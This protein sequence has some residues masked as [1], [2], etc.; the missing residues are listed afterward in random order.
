MKK[1]ITLFLAMCLICGISY[2][3]SHDVYMNSLSTSETEDG[4]SW[5]TAFKTFGKL[6]EVLIPSMVPGDHYEIWISQGIYLLYDNVEFSDP[7]VGSD[8]VEVVLRGGCDGTETE[9]GQW[10]PRGHVVVIKAMVTGD[11]VRL[12]NEGDLEVGWVSFTD[13]M[14]PAITGEADCTIKNCIFDSCYCG[15]WLGSGSIYDTVFAKCG[16]GSTTGADSH[17]QGAFVCTG[18]VS[19]Y[20][21]TFLLNQS[22]G[23]TAGII[24]H[25]T[26]PHTFS[27]PSGP[28]VQNSIFWA[29][30]LDEYPSVSSF[31]LEELSYLQD[32]WKNDLL[33]SDMEFYSEGV[34][35]SS[36]I[37]KDFLFSMGNPSWY[38]TP[39]PQYAL[40]RYTPDNV[41]N[42]CRDAGDAYDSRPYDVYGRSRLFGSKIDMGA[43][44]YV[45]TYIDFSGNPKQGTSS[46]K[47]TVVLSSETIDTVNSRIKL[48]QG[49]WK[50]DMELFVAPS[51]GSTLPGVIVNSIPGTLDINI[52]YWV[53]FVTDGFELYVNG[54]AGST[55]ATRVYF[56]SVGSGS[57]VAG[58]GVAY[59]A[60]EISAS[61]RFD[62][63]N[64]R[65]TLTHGYWDN[66]GEISFEIVTG[67]LPGNVVASK[68]YFLDAKTPVMYYWSIHDLFSGETYQIAPE[69]SAPDPIPV[70]TFMEFVG[71]VVDGSTNVDS[72]ADT[73]KL[74]SGGTSTIPSWENGLKVQVRCSGDYPGNLYPGTDY[75]TGSKT[76]VSGGITVQLL[77]SEGGSAVDIS[78]PGVGNIAIYLAEGETIPGKTTTPVTE[79]WSPYDQEKP[80]ST[81]YNGIVLY[82]SDWIDNELVVISSDESD[83][84]KDT[85]DHIKIAGIFADSYTLHT[86]IGGPGVDVTYGGSGTC[87]AV[88]RNTPVSLYTNFVDES[89]VENGQIVGW[90]W[91]FDADGTV[92]STEQNPS[93]LYSNEGIYSVRLTL[94][95]RPDS[96]V[97]FEDSVL[98]DNYITVARSGVLLDAD[99]TSDVRCG[100]SP[101]SVSFI[102]NTSS[103]E[104]TLSYNWDFGDG[105]TSTE[106]NPIHVYDNP[107][108]YTVKYT[109]SYMGEKSV[110]EKK[111]YVFVPN[112]LNARFSVDYRMVTAPDYEVNLYDE[113]Y[114]F[115]YFTDMTPAVINSWSWEIYD[116]DNVLRKSAT[117]TNVQFNEYYG[118]GKY[119]VKLTI[120]TDDGTA[121]TDIT[122]AFEILSPV[123]LGFSVSN[124]FIRPGESVF[125]QNDSLL[126]TVP[127]KFTPDTVE[128]EVDGPGGSP[129]ITWSG[130][131][132]MENKL[133]EAMVLP[134]VG[135]YSVKMTV[136]GL[137]SGSVPA[138]YDIEE[139]NSILV[140]EGF[141]SSLNA[142][143]RLGLVPLR[144]NFKD[145]SYY[146]SIN[147][148]DTW[149]WEYGDGGANLWRD[150]AK[151]DASSE[152]S[153]T[154]IP[155][156][157]MHGPQNNWG[158]NLQRYSFMGNRVGTYSFEGTYSDNGIKSPASFGEDNE[159]VLP[160][161]SSLTYDA[162]NH[163]FSPSYSY[164][165][166]GAYTVSLT[167]DGNKITKQDYVEAVAPVE[168][169]FSTRGKIGDYPL[170]VEFIPSV[171]RYNFTYPISYEWEFEGGTPST[172]TQKYP[173]VQYPIPSDMVFKNAYVSHYDVSLTV[174]LGNW[175]TK[176]VKRGYVEAFPP[177]F[178]KLSWRILSVEGTSPDEVYNVELSPQLFL[179]RP[180]DRI[181]LFTYGS[182]EYFNSRTQTVS[183]TSADGKCT[184]EYPSGW[185]MPSLL[186][187]VQSQ[188][189]RPFSII[190]TTHFNPPVWND[191]TSQV[192]CGSDI[193]IKSSYYPRQGYAPLKVSAVYNAFA[194]NDEITRMMSIFLGQDLSTHI[195]SWN[196]GDPNRKGFLR[197]SCVLENPGEYQ[198][199]FLAQSSKGQQVVSLDSL[200][201]L[202]S[203]VPVADFSI[204]SAA[205]EGA[206]PVKGIVP[207]QV[208]FFDNSTVG[209]SSITKWVWNFGDSGMSMDQNPVHTYFRQGVYSVSLTITTKS[210]KTDTMVRDGIVRAMVLPTADFTY[211]FIPNAF[212]GTPTTFLV[213]RH[214]TSGNEDGKTWKTGF[215]T[216]QEAV[217]AAHD[218]GGG[219]VW[220]STGWYGYESNILNSTYYFDSVGGDYSGNT[221]NE[222]NEIDSTGCSDHLKCSVVVLPGGVNIY[223]GFDLKDRSLYDRDPKKNV[224]VVSGTLTNPSISNTTKTDCVIQVE[225]DSIVDG[226]TILGGSARGR[227]FDVDGSGF[228]CYEYFGFGGGINAENSD[229]EISNCRFAF[230]ASL[231]GGGAVA[232]QKCTTQIKNC[233]FVG[234]MSCSGSCVMAFDPTATSSV[235]DSYLNIQDS[236]F[237]RNYSGASF[238]ATSVS[239][240]GEKHQSFYSGYTSLQEVVMEP[241]EGH[242]V[243]VPKS[244]N[245]SDETAVNWGNV[246]FVN[247]SGNGFREGAHG[248]IYML[249][250][251]KVTPSCVFKRIVEGSD[252]VA[253][254][255]EPIAYCIENDR[256][257]RAL[258]ANPIE[259]CDGIIMF[260]LDNASMEVISD[261]R[262]YYPNLVQSVYVTIGEYVSIDGVPSSLDGDPDFTAKCSISNLSVA[263]FEYVSGRLVYLDYVSNQIIP[264]EGST[265]G[266]GLEYFDLYGDFS[267]IENGTIP[268]DSVEIRFTGSSSTLPSAG[269]E[270]TWD[271][272]SKNI[273]RVAIHSSILTQ[274]YSTLSSTNNILTKIFYVGYDI[275]FGIEYSNG[276]WVSFYDSD[277]SEGEYTHT[278]PFGAVWFEG[279]QG[280]IA[281]CVFEDNFSVGG[282]V[283]YSPD[284]LIVE[285]SS[286]E[287]NRGGL[288]GA[289]A[290]VLEKSMIGRSSVVIDSCKFIG[291]EAFGNYGGAVS[292]I[293]NAS[294]YDEDT[295]LPF[296]KVSDPFD[297][298]NT[299]SPVSAR[300]VSIR[301]CF[302]SGNKSEQYGSAIAHGGTSRCVVLHSTFFDN[303]SDNK[304]SVFSNLF[305]GNNQI[306]LQTGPQ[307]SILNSIL[308][309]HN[310]ED[311]LCIAYEGSSLVLKD[312]IV[313][314][315]VSTQ[316][317]V[318][319]LVDNISIEN[320][321]TVEGYPPY[322][323]K[324]LD[325]SGNYVDIKKQGHIISEDLLAYSDT[326]STDSDY[327]SLIRPDWKDS[328][329]VR[330]YRIDSNGETLPDD[331]Q[332]YGAIKNKAE[333]G[334]QL[335][336][337]GGGFN[338]D[339]VDPHEQFYL[340]NKTPIFYQFKNPSTGDLIDLQSY[341]DLLD[342]TDNAGYVF[343]IIGEES[344]W[345]HTGYYSQ[346]PEANRVSNGGFED[347]SPIPTSWV[348]EAG[349]GAEVTAALVTT[350][351]NSGTNAWQIDTGS[352]D[353]DPDGYVYQDVPTDRITPGATYS[354]Y[355]YTRINTGTPSGFKLEVWNDGAAIQTMDL[356]YTSSYVRTTDTFVAPE[357][358]VNFQLRIY[359]GTVKSVSVYV[360]DVGISWY[361][362]SSVDNLDTE[363]DTISFANP[364]SV[365]EDH[366]LK[367]NDLIVF[368]TSDALL[369]ITA[370]VPY[371]LY[372]RSGT[373]PNFTFKMKDYESDTNVDLGDTF[374]SKFTSKIFV[375]REEFLS[376]EVNT[377]EDTF[378]SFEDFSHFPLET[379]PSD[380]AFF[381][382][383][384]GTSPQGLTENSFYDLGE[385]SGTDAAYNLSTASIGEP[386][387][388]IT[389]YGYG[390]VDLSEFTEEVDLDSKI[391]PENDMIQFANSDYVRFTGSSDLYCFA[392][393][394]RNNPEWTL[395]IGLSEDVMYRSNYEYVIRGKK[396]RY[397]ERY[398]Y[399]ID[400]DIVG[401][402]SGYMYVGK[403]V[404]S[405]ERFPSYKE[406]DLLSA[407]HDVV[408]IYDAFTGNPLQEFE[409]NSGD[410]VVFKFSPISDSVTG[411]DSGS[412]YWLYGKIP[413]KQ[414][415]VASIIEYE[416]DYIDFRREDSDSLFDINSNVGYFDSDEVD[417]NVGGDSSVDYI[418]LPEDISECYE[419][420]EVGSIVVL[421]EYLKYQ[422]H[423]NGIKLG[424][425]GSGSPGQGEDP[426]GG[427]PT[428]GY[429][430]YVIHSFAPEGYT[431]TAPNP[432]YAAVYVRLASID[433][434]GTPI[435]IWGSTSTPSTVRAF[436]KTTQAEF[437]YAIYDEA[438]PGY[439]GKIHF[440]SSLYGNDLNFVFVLK[441]GDVPSFF[442]NGINRVFSATASTYF[443]T[444]SHLYYVLNTDTDT[445]TEP[446]Y[447]EF[448]PNEGL[449]YTYNFYC[450]ED[451]NKILLGTNVDANKDV[452]LLSNPPSDLDSIRVF[453]KDGEGRY[454]AGIDSATRYNLWYDANYLSSGSKYAYKLISGDF[455]DNILRAENIVDIKTSGTGILVVSRVLEQDIPL[456]PDVLTD[457]DEYHSLLK[458]SV[459]LRDDQNRVM[460]HSLD[461]YHEWSSG[462]QVMFLTENSTSLTKIIVPEY[463]VEGYGAD[464]ITE[465]DIY[466][467]GDEIGSSGR[468]YL[469][470]TQHT[471]PIKVEFTTSGSSCE[472]SSIDIP[473]GIRFPGS[474]FAFCPQETISNIASKVNL[475]NS[476]ILFTK[477]LWNIREKA[478]LEEKKVILAFKGTDLP[479]GL[480]QDVPYLAGFQSIEGNDV[481]YRVVLYSFPKWQ[482]SALENGIEFSSAS[483]ITLSD[484]G[485]GSISVWVSR[486]VVGLG[487]E[488]DTD[489][490][491][492][493]SN[494]V[495]LS[496]GG[497]YY[498][499]PYGSTS[500]ISFP[501]GNSLDISD[502]SLRNQ[503]R[504]GLVGDIS[505]SIRLGSDGWYGVEPD[506]KIKICDDRWKVGNEVSFYTGEGSDTVVELPIGKTFRISEFSDAGQVP[507]RYMK[508]VNASDN[509]KFVPQDTYS[510][511]LTMY[512][513]SRVNE[514]AEIDSMSIDLQKGSIRLLN[515]EWEIG[516]VVSV[517][518]PYWS[519]YPYPL[520]EGR[521]YLIDSLLIGNGYNEAGLYDL[522]SKSSTSFTD[523]AR[524]VIQMNG[525]MYLGQFASTNIFRW[526]G[527]TGSNLSESFRDDKSDITSINVDEDTIDLIRQDWNNEE[528]I[529]FNST[530]VYSKDVV[531]TSPADPA[532]IPEQTPSSLPLNFE[533]V[534][535]ERIRGVTANRRCYDTLYVPHFGVNAGEVLAVWGD[536]LIRVYLGR[537]T[538]NPDEPTIPG[539]IGDMLFEVKETNTIKDV[540]FAPHRGRI[541]VVTD[542]KKSPLRAYGVGGNPRGKFTF[543]NPL[544]G[545]FVDNVIGIESDIQNIY[546]TIVL[547]DN[548]LNGES[549]IYYV[550]NGQASGRSPINLDYNFIPPSEVDGAIP[551]A[552][553]SYSPSYPSMPNLL[554][555]LYSN[556]KVVCYDVGNR[557]SGD[558]SPLS[559]GIFSYEGTDSPS[560]QYLSLS[561]YGEGTTGTAKV[562]FFV[563]SPEGV[564]FTG[565]V[566][567]TISSGA[568]VAESAHTAT[569]P[570]GS[571]WSQFRY[572]DE[573]GFVIDYMSRRG[574]FSKKEGGTFSWPSGEIEFEQRFGADGH[575]TAGDA[576]F[577]CP[578]ILI[579]ISG[580][581]SSSFEY[582]NYG[583]FKVYDVS[584][585]TY[586]SEPIIPE[587]DSSV[588]LAKAGGVIYGK[589]GN[590]TPPLG[591]EV[592]KKYTLSDKKTSDSPRDPRI[593]S[594]SP[595]VDMGENISLRRDLYGQ[596]RPFGEGFDSGVHEYHSDSPKEP[597]SLKGSMYSIEVLEDNSLSL[598]EISLKSGSLKSR[599][600]TIGKEGHV[601]VG[602]TGQMFL[603]SGTWS[604]G[605]AS[606]TGPYNLYR[607]NP[608]D[609]TTFFL[610]SLP[611][612]VIYCAQFAPN[613]ALCLIAKKTSSEDPNMYVVST[614]DASTAKIT[615]SIDLGSMSVAD[616]R[617]G[618]FLIQTPTEGMGD[619]EY[620]NF[621]V[622]TTKK[623]WVGSLVKIS[624]DE[625]KL[626]FTEFDELGTDIYSI[627]LDDD[628][629]MFGCGLLGDRNIYELVRS[630]EY[631][632]ARSATVFADNFSFDDTKCIQ[633]I[634]IREAGATHTGVYQFPI[635]FNDR[636]VSPGCSIHNWLWDFGDNSM[637][638]LQNPVH[639][640][641]WIGSYPVKMGV[642]NDVG[643]DIITKTL[644]IGSLTGPNIFIWDNP[645]PSPWDPYT[646]K[647]VTSVKMGRANTSLPYVE[648]YGGSVSLVPEGDGRFFDVGSGIYLVEQSAKVVSQSS[649]SWSY[650]YV[651][652]LDLPDV[653]ENHYTENEWV[654]SPEEDM[655]VGSYFTGS[656]E[657]DPISFRRIHSNVFP[658]GDTSMVITV[659]IMST[660]SSSVLTS[661]R[662]VEELPTPDTGSWSFNSVVGVDGTLTT[663]PDPD[664]TGALEFVWG[665]IPTTYPIQ[666]VYSVNIPSLDHQDAVTFRGTMYYY[667]AGEEKSP[668]GPVATTTQDNCDPNIPY[669]P[670]RYSF[671]VSV[672]PINPLGLDPVG[673]F[674][675]KATT[676]HPDLVPAVSPDAELTTYDGIGEMIDITVVES[677][678]CF[679][680]HNITPGD[681]LHEPTLQLNSYALTESTNLFVNFSDAPPTAVA[682]D[683]S[684]ELDE[685]G[686]VPITP[687]MVDDGSS[688]PGDCGGVTLSTDVTSVDCSSGTSVEGIL[689]ARDVSLQ[690]STD[691]FTI[692]V[693]DPILPELTLLANYTATLEFST[694]DVNPEDLVDTA[695]DN[696]I[697]LSYQIKKDGGVYGDSISYDCTEL[698]NNT[699]WVKIEDPFGN[700]DEASMTVVVEEGAYDCMQAICNSDPINLTADPTTVIL[701]MVDGGSLGYESYDI[702][703]SS[704]DCGDVGTDVEITLTVYAGP[705]QTGE[706]KSCTTS[707]RITDTGDICALTGD[708]VAVCISISPFTIGATVELTAAELDGGSYV[709]G[710]SDLPDLYIDTVGN[711]TKT[712]TCSELGP[713]TVTLIAKYGAN[714]STCDV[715]VTVVPGILQVMAESIEVEL[716]QITK[717][718]TVH[719]EDFSPYIGGTVY[720]PL[721]DEPTY[722]L[723]ETSS[724]YPHIPYPPELSEITFTCYDVGLNWISVGSGFIDFMYPI[725]AIVS[726]NVLDTVADCKNYILRVKITDDVPTK[727]VVNELPVEDHF[728]VINLDTGEEEW[729][730]TTGGVATVQLS[731]AVKGQNTA[732]KYAPS[733]PY[734]GYP[735]EYWITPVPKNLTWTLTTFGPLKFWLADTTGVYTYV[736]QSTPTV[737]QLN[738]SAVT[739]GWQV[740]PNIAGVNERLAQ[741]H[742]DGGSPGDEEDGL[743]PNRSPGAH[744]YG[745]A[746]RGSAY[747]LTNLTNPAVKDWT[748]A[749]NDLVYAGDVRSNPSYPPAMKTI[750]PKTGS[751]Y[752]TPGVYLLELSLPTGNWTVDVTTSTPDLVMIYHPTIEASW[753]IYV[754]AKNISLGGY[755]IINVSMTRRMASFYAAEFPGSAPMVPYDGANNTCFYY[756]VGSIDPV[757]KRVDP[758][759]PERIHPNSIQEIPA[760]YIYSEAQIPRAGYS[761]CQE[762][763]INSI[764]VWYN[765]VPLPDY[766]ESGTIQ[767]NPGYYASYYGNGWM[768]WLL[769]FCENYEYGHSGKPVPPSGIVWTISLWDAEWTYTGGPCLCIGCLDE[770]HDPPRCQISGS[771]CGTMVPNCA[772]RF[773]IYN[774]HWAA[775]CTFGDDSDC[776]GSNNECW[777]KFYLY[778]GGSYTAC[779]P[780]M[781]WSSGGF[782]EPCNN[783]T[784]LP[785]LLSVF[786]TFAWD[787]SQE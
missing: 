732:I 325:E 655:N 693:S 549:G 778:M 773:D 75:W 481:E 644:N 397:F 164:K 172:S 665:T 629:K 154:V 559:S 529:Y 743:L 497:P 227:Y 588:D 128:Y 57:M 176:V 36:M 300:E 243:L 650:D 587:G 656:S 242:E 722:F 206:K 51:Y 217:N 224:T 771:E 645:I 621:Y 212:L 537:D 372:D 17:V 263:P 506:G 253:C 231:W 230:N 509:S 473:D 281:D 125:I 625:K 37:E 550:D 430:Y 555:V 510:G 31:V 517:T 116:P 624:E 742:N 557:T 758:D 533:K 444:G 79:Q 222:T 150:L 193:E 723:E 738:F 66:T 260:E 13:F 426:D 731:E 348:V 451:S 721:V 163:V 344:F 460:Y 406:S 265:G 763:H 209:G 346:N 314:G 313:D 309:T 630:P 502:P 89:V 484:V 552:I 204:T 554:F 306:T 565:G 681:I 673:K 229:L 522:L 259:L 499:F 120:G 370:G 604:S 707:H 56:T 543:T 729:F 173:V 16:R 585:L 132:D 415:R 410:P 335:S 345:E 398:P 146:G 422:S 198:A 371:L 717:T 631:I 119:R 400:T 350:P 711:T 601:I 616:I 151:L 652:D 420:F 138:S 416:A 389:E 127:E 88:F 137:L 94:S 745:E 144:V 326:F 584:D 54:K 39:T 273:I 586:S 45:D 545:K 202:D 477:S 623:L 199:F 402:G 519:R 463:N 653:E 93:Y 446:D 427:Y 336:T 421:T 196:K 548:Y 191:T 785:T 680:F 5:T 72:E 396:C 535:P 74:Q 82:G 321:D 62:V 541:M 724:A 664:Q 135:E 342:G 768:P 526:E 369:G 445:P 383:R 727:D 18:I 777:I 121:V 123:K 190:P 250:V 167:S 504:T 672:A 609:A 592:G 401:Y 539:N 496:D 531:S 582:P 706:S 494:R 779:Y 411:I 736:P 297:L 417:M 169:D 162:N 100:I 692:T 569:Y 43:S 312:S 772:G 636:S 257:E 284:N 532:A 81:V 553:R 691:T 122:D 147:P 357:S 669:D 442:T 547:T 133:S 676:G 471:T 424:G 632:E 640:Y 111:G 334:V 781:C 413:W 696:C 239:G 433:S 675:I 700:T 251:T 41:P 11:P 765:G 714:Q 286:F 524:A 472:D 649:G 295:G 589:P 567:I 319:N 544:S 558:V 311:D 418:P 679:S 323:F 598:V 521:S 660:I 208:K 261:S 7:L 659:E 118:C 188:P 486:S 355:C 694:V 275:G 450:G 607:V 12:F 267:L 86:T 84:F 246:C 479:S 299:E 245:R 134:S 168:I 627:A 78:Y 95:I 748:Q 96:G 761:E 104:T 602:H 404:S 353:G 705:G 661:I 197:Q 458:N 720:C 166:P 760:G 87:R 747:K 368:N 63:E 619:V 149:Y 375:L 328:N 153:I 266:D 595:A 566:T 478:V 437:P 503:V 774:N 85:V 395:P 658:C 374:D 160:E 407:D 285:S 165:S 447:V 53:K 491:R 189:T 377:S 708:P 140:G 159:G 61:E 605:G 218:V 156:Y 68:R 452:I 129:H 303:Y 712:W 76:E 102:D 361:E 145:N 71:E 615:S 194:P 356:S 216:I 391:L 379:S 697:D 384:N 264:V 340:I 429:E 642:M 131:W 99:F 67:L 298:Y 38:W 512:R 405:V 77:S 302:F 525:S 663:Q 207:Y 749:S 15:A 580:S 466:I 24:S 657:Y 476:S 611:F 203:Q 367:D 235:N 279:S 322:T 786:N 234:N 654:I 225:G 683:I 490:D 540:V 688:D 513:V 136:S 562:K 725:N 456:G 574:F 58:S 483:Q 560:F 274:N 341:G 69:L 65:V 366:Y 600:G 83:E 349:T 455:R 493:Y 614:L 183:G 271:I 618:T 755:P 280:R 741:F 23:S 92:D 530:T 784:V 606:L 511:W 195:K 141:S 641:P 109:V 776:D 744:Y 91:D 572:S 381:Y 561:D 288:G 514:V 255:I 762:Q 382:V 139:E 536:H 647:I 220:V 252:P 716:D 317:D 599:I 98:K 571:I 568:A 579:G 364:G 1:V 117:T 388:N 35:G 296:L 596:T 101:L 475:T 648:G 726:V 668:Y 232:A 105:E 454:P 158:E 184:F 702:A 394:V 440:D 575:C 704:V 392:V 620:R 612:D 387:I 718:V 613:N 27:D 236:W 508:L 32:S 283:V 593:N 594:G 646:L 480:V 441:D 157:E 186:V 362:S 180:Y 403:K 181:T 564:L 213:N 701:A 428:S 591:V 282:G 677:N 221:A 301:N 52:R 740:P 358:F 489:L 287:N 226:F 495:N 690:E 713:H 185:A 351:V 380:N 780:P 201:V 390:S 276:L 465:G 678:D 107:G 684:V 249:D 628:D 750:Y 528:D 240:D 425:N 423:F 443:S 635:Q 412:V 393:D 746:W 770:G 365:D 50:D 759:I 487:A 320:P 739:Y 113:S 152:S 578:Y 689:T 90:K 682:K 3:A 182:G 608:N 610:G 115:N 10:D 699:A 378:R 754:R 19:V 363:A 551:L 737:I 244:G 48:L 432:G 33:T 464:S 751:G 305:D 29:N 686:V 270:A 170:T 161:L 34:Y 756:F 453:L 171:V 327:V 670:I 438:Y 573:A 214:N 459:R 6:N 200:R 633:A 662:L 783:E 576:T 590:F 47:E 626:V 376:F 331:L 187:T 482:I 248:S 316:L 8:E 28:Y 710:S 488:I 597:G 449:F 148:P 399:S 192:R 73:V 730:I 622:G 637:G 238:I 277:V 639:I 667:L 457:T 354:V 25:P 308:W 262:T 289:V 695:T 507:Y 666:L 359:P 55:Y 698:G 210:G 469:A 177:V 258:L 498:L 175:Q 174:R 728:A 352:V 787:T 434:P 386:A 474:M 347:G 505:T 205:R 42:E 518:S 752:L 764:G 439:A 735:G 638:S 617:F 49:W 2:S 470:E 674:K 467:V 130:A 228:G 546:D 103:S 431:S 272:R 583:W 634:S 338:P 223:G 293:Q 60:E 241:R 291:N 178:G 126:R 22:T 581:G 651:R 685:D 409:F 97:I 782:S 64:N 114:V 414:K 46:P 4:Q 523:F 332:E 237:Y 448:T 333:G 307:Y 734:F 360:D 461:D 44:E 14:S 577:N 343:P 269:I 324:L 462:Q 435:Q 108:Y 315:F 436:T 671:K 211:E 70:F 643:M 538:F 26:H 492:F 757:I 515:D 155:V 709:S 520:F 769:D 112:V 329:F 563:G 21:C 110:R 318:D 733:V 256:G 468:F 339:P 500:N 294:L 142:T 715:E 215:T 687:D 485:S 527:Y 80:S 219:D 556:N 268:V 310:I 373:F 719:P 59:Y 767:S 603:V 775:R 330:M 766:C 106:F 247:I 124:N 233:E 516:D 40:A 534:F 9:I 304:V 408:E 385:V 753:R 501:T 278:T 292:N 254:T 570:V 290:L 30:D 20:N 337:D 703:P 542:D 143:P 179:S 419:P